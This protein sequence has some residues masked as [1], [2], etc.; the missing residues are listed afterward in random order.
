M[1]RCL[2]M[3]TWTPWRGHIWWLKTCSLNLNTIKQ[4]CSPPC[5]LSPSLNY[6]SQFAKNGQALHRIH[7]VCCLLSSWIFVAVRRA[8]WWGKVLWSRDSESIKS[9]AWH[10][11]LLRSCYGMTSV[12]LQLQHSSS[13][14]IAQW[15]EQRSQELLSHA[16]RVWVSKHFMLSCWH[17]V[18]EHREYTLHIVPIMPSKEPEC[19][20]MEE[21][22]TR[23][24]PAP[25]GK[26]MVLVRVCYWIIEC[27]C[28]HACLSH[29]AHTPDL[30]SV[31]MQESQLCLFNWNRFPPVALLRWTWGEHMTVLIPNVS[32]ITFSSYKL[33]SCVYV[34][35][36]HELLPH[37]RL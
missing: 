33:K 10:C 5:D 34:Q 18:D 2:W 11:V 12:S 15:T 31:M 24:R 25:T 1:P 21:N 37:V 28:L 30:P 32:C 14:F 3:D 8:L 6:T 22:P 9:I 36:C 19:M 13:Q 17:G 26:P 20:G 35:Q 27:V 7:Q 16:T 29:D 23:I 4:A